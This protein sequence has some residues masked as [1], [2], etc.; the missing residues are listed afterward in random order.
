[1]PKAALAGFVIEIDST[2]SRILYATF[3]GGSD[4]DRITGIAVD[5]LRRI[6]VTGAT[7]SRDF[8]TTANAWGQ[9]SHGEMDA[10]YAKID[11]SVAGLAGLMYSTLLGGSGSDSGDAIAVDLAGRAWIAGRTSS[12]ADFPAVHPVQDSGGGHDDAFIAEI[13][14]ARSGTA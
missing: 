6:H 2:A 7:T 5:E 12:S 4:T 14:P 1:M 10:F 3:L 9:A 13:D 8:P 11:P